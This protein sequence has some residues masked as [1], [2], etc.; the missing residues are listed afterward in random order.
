[1]I[2]RVNIFLNLVNAT[3]ISF[4]HIPFPEICSDILYFLVKRLNSLVVNG[5]YYC[6]GVC[7][8]FRPDEQDTCSVV[9]ENE[10]SDGEDGYEQ[11]DGFRRISESE[12][13]GEKN[14]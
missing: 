7:K 10:H 5:E 1:M 3:L 8:H 13:N 12:P 11:E 14:D 6:Q 9:E 4:I 2:H